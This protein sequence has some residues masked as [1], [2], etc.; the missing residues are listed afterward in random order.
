MFDFLNVAGPA[1]WRAG[2]LAAGLALAGCSSSDAPAGA[3]ATAKPAAPVAAPVAT[4][5]LTAAAPVYR[6]RLPGELKPYQQVDIF[7]RVSAFVKQVLV[8]RGSAVTTGQT[9][10]VLEAPELAAQLARARSRWQAAQAKL[11]G[12][13]ASYDRLLRTS[14][15]PGTISP[16][17]LE[18]ARADM[19]TDQANVQAAYSELQ[20]SR[21]LR[22]YLVVRAPFSGVVSARNVSAGA[23]VGPG[24]GQPAA[25][26]FSM[27]DNRTLRLEVAVP[28]AVDG[29][30]L[31]PGARVPFT[32][33]AFP[34]RTFSGIYRR[35]ADRLSQ[36]V[37]S[38]LVEMDVPNPDGRLKAGMYAQVLVALPVPAGSRAV[39]TSAVFTTPTQPKQ[40]QVI[41]VQEGHAR[42]VPVRKGQLLSRDTVQV[43]GPLAPGDALLREASDQVANG[44]RV[45]VAPAAG[46]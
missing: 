21:E 20:A 38:E 15:E 7:P 13:K 5:R 4:F 39:P 1:R 22:N 23:L 37:R 45:T 35:Q 27:E 6:L 12:T 9:L 2:L 31:R 10:A 44:Q 26:L 46:A 14:Q 32:V 18:R 16:N 36:A 29:H 43:F 30:W 41:R 33:P 42:W 25:P 3:E 40:S 34:G 19:Q 8:D 11:S 24:A 17:D 28:E